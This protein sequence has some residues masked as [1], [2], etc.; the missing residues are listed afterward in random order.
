MAGWL[1]C[2]KQLGEDT[3]ARCGRGAI[4]GG[5]DASAWRRS[6]GTAGRMVEAIGCRA[7][8]AA[9]AD[10]AGEQ[11]EAGADASGE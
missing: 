10:V 4:V 3:A 5:L 6:R 2:W 8:V 11:L 1:Q 7:D 9:E